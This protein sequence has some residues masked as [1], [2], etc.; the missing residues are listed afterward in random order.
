[1]TFEDDIVNGNLNEFHIKKFQKDIDMYKDQLAVHLQTIGILVAEKTEI[2]STLQQYHKKIEKQQEEIDELNGRLKQAKQR[3]QE[4]E[5]QLS[6]NHSN[7]INIDLLKRD[8]EEYI[9]NIKIN[10]NTKLYIVKF[11]LIS[12]MNFYL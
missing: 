10:F 8:Y 3:L 5:N 7:E 4:V 1:M 12:C 2:Q 9:E 11:N 6:N